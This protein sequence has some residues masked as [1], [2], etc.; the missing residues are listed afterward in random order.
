MALS[1]RTANAIWGRSA[2]RCY[3]DPSEE[4]TRTPA[5]SVPIGEIAHIVARSP[6]G[7]R[8][9]EARSSDELDAP[10]NLILVCPTHHAE[11][12]THPDVW[13][14]DRLHNL[15]RHHEE[16]VLEQLSHYSGWNPDA[17]GRS[18]VVVGLETA[19]V[20]RDGVPR[21]GFAVR[22]AGPDA[23]VVH[24]VQ[25]E[26]LAVDVRPSTVQRER[27]LAGSMLMARTP[28]SFDLATADTDVPLVATGRFSR[29]DGHEVALELAVGERHL[30]SGAIQPG[31]FRAGVFRIIARYWY[32]PEPPYQAVASENFGLFE[33]PDDGRTIH[34]GSRST[35]TADDWPRAEVLDLGA[36]VG[37]ADPLA[38]D[39][40]ANTRAVAQ[41]ALGRVP[42]SSARAVIGEW[43][44]DPSRTEAA[45]AA[46]A[47]AMHDPWRATMIERALSSDVVSARRAAVQILDTFL[48]REASGAEEALWLKAL[49]DE[50]DE[51]RVAAA[52]RL[53]GPHLSDCPRL[54]ARVRAV[55]ESTEPDRADDG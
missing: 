17:T 33:V 11:I 29:P 42:R 14:P 31:D 38:V 54:E 37:L 47:A 7:P 12:D 20:D 3:L 2:G 32:W 10:D 34:V 50:A 6:A 36:L 27:R 26:V 8:G 4:L 40:S 35:Q 15:K 55:R 48:V 46:L 30:F 24:I 22:N 13:T 52:E 53:L 23:V 44:N 1:R 49:S 18:G 25:A 45:L 43:L 28:V 41:H 51:V 19:S 39:A 16:W 5:G 21:F 9:S